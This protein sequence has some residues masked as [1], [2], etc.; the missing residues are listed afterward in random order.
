MRLA[1]YLVLAALSA[2]AYADEP[3]L[4][5]VKELEAAKKRGLKQTV[6]VPNPFRCPTVA[7]ST[8]DLAKF[9]ETGAMSVLSLGIAGFLREDF[10]VPEAV[11]LLG[12]NV[13]CSRRIVGSSYAN[14]EL[15]PRSKDIDSITLELH[16]GALIG[17]VIGLAK[18]ISVDIAK[19]AK[20]HGTSRKM[21]N[22]HGP[23]GDSID[24]KTPAFSAQLMFEPDHADATKVRSVIYRRTP[25]IEILPDKFLAAADV[26]RL[27]KLA[28]RPVAPEPVRF[29]GT[30][31][32]VD[33]TASTPDRAVM[34]PA[35]DMR[36]VAAASIAR[37]KT[38][39]REEVTSIDVTFAK[40]VT[41][42]AA[43]LAKALGAKPPSGKGK[44]ATIEV[45]G[46]VVRVD[47]AKGK[48]A[49][50]VIER[51]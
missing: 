26:A 43:A 33:R 5:A 32:V 12:E 38:G 4:D 15:A 9:R 39:D 46:G 30:L 8:A 20:R 2:V 45:T 13:L 49:R 3:K 1:C 37:T 19:L 21:P 16:D 28:V 50:V 48:I 41:G 29:Y 51:R 47:L 44:S 25:M 27:V 35:I 40:A 11:A 23:S 34:S 6:I 14:Y 17:V 31:G 18:P 36:N 7:A 10:D 22:L 42:D 24:A